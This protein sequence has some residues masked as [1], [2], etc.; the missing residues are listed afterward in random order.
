MC[1]RACNRFGAGR[2]RSFVGSAT[3]A[4]Q[5]VG[6]CRDAE[7]VSTDARRHWRVERDSEWR[8]QAP[9]RRGNVAVP[10]FARWCVLC[11]LC[12]WHMGTGD[13]IL[14]CVMLRRVDGGRD[15]RTGSFFY[16]SAGLRRLRLFARRVVR[17]SSAFSARA[18]TQRQP[19]R[20]IYCR[21]AHAVG[22]VRLLAGDE[23]GS[24]TNR[25]SAAAPT[26]TRR[27]RVCFV[28]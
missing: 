15:G 24:S 16:M 20:R 5:M 7:Y 18:A 23:E 19:T 12:K 25:A 21:T 8:A 27:R 22:S 17:A 2:G 10:V 13:T 3:L 6:R 11:D 26:P 9:A 14:Y 28:A 4:L 1:A